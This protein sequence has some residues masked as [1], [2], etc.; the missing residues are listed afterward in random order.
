MLFAPQYTQAAATANTLMTDT[1]YAAVNCAAESMSHRCREEN[2]K[3]YPTIK[4]YGLQGYNE[5]SM[6]Q[7]G[8][9]EPYPYAVEG[10]TEL[11]ARN[12]FKSVD[13]MVEWIQSY[14][15]LVT[16]KQVTETVKE[17]FGIGNLLKLFFFEFIF[18]V[19]Y[20]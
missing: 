11:Y 5:K 4:V 8:M 3:F 6:E 1:V 16:A 19:K 7:M 10:R 20:N 15:G 17:I 9:P 18:Q 12:R 2:V 13:H 14:A